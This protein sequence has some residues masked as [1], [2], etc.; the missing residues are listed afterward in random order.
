MSSSSTG[1]FQVYCDMTTDGG[2]WILAFDDTSSVQVKQNINPLIKG[3]K[4]SKILVYTG[5]NTPSTHAL[6]GT[7]NSLDTA[8]SSTWIFSGFESDDFKYL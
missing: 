5:S 6:S 4:I 1:T 2:G 3:I 7:I 8:F